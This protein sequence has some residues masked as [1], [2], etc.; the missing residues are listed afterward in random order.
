MKAN[1]RIGV[2]LFLFF[3]IV[4][5][6]QAQLAG[7]P[8]EVQTRMNQDYSR[9]KPAFEAAYE[10]CPTVPRGMLESVAYNYTRFSAPEW[11][12]TLDVD[13]NTIPRTYS[14][15]GLT[16]SGKGFFR[17]NLRLVSELSG[18][19]V[20]EIIRQD[21]MAI[22]AYALAFSSLQK[23][24]NC[25]GK[26]L[27]I[28]KPVLIDLSE[29]P[30]E[31]DFALLSSLYVIYFVFIDGILFHFGIP[32]FNVDFNILFGEKSAMLQQSN[33]SLD[34][35]YEQKATS[36][37]DYPSAVWN[38]AAS[39]NY[40]SRNGTQVSNVTIHY[41]SGTYAGSIAWFQNCAAKVS[42]H[43]V[44]RSI[45]GQ[46]TQMVRESSKAWHVGVAN[47]Y[48][49]GIEHEAY[50]N[51]A[52]FFTYNMYLSSA[53]LVRN[54]CSRYANI[55]P[56][57]VFYRDTL[58][59][60]TVLNNGLHSLGG[61]T[62]CTQIRGHQHFPSQT[63]TDPG[64]Y[65]DWNFYYKLINYPPQVDSVTSSTGVFY[66][67][68]GA[69]GNYQN[70]ERKLFLIHV[71]NADSVVLEFT[72]FQLEPNYD[73]IWIYAGKTEF[74]PLVGRW[75]THSPGRVA[76][77]GEY[78][79]VEFRS[80][81][82]TTAA[83]WKANWYGVFSQQQQDAAP[84]QTEIV[85]DHHEWIT[86]DFQIRFRDTDDVAVKY[87]FYQLMEHP[88][89]YWTANTQQGFLC[90]NFDAALSAS[91][92]YGDGYWQ[93][94]NGQLLHTPCMISPSWINKQLNGT[95][96]KGYLYDF[97]LAMQD[98]GE[99]SFIF[100]SNS[101]VQNQLAHAYGVTFCKSDNS[102]RMWKQQ[103][104]VMENL[105]TVTHV[106]YATGQ[107]MLYR[108][109]WDTVAHRIMVFRHSSL[110][111][112]VSVPQPVSS[113]AE[114]VGFITDGVGVSIDNMR[115][116]GMRDTSVLVTVGEGVDRML[117]T[118]ASGG[119]PT[120]KIKSV[121]M[122]EG[123]NFSALSE[124][125]VLV[126]YT[127]PD[128]PRKVRLRKENA[129]GGAE[130]G[131]LRVEAEWSPATDNQSGIKC[132]HYIYRLEGNNGPVLKVAWEYVGLSTSC[133]RKICTMNGMRLMVGV[134]AMDEAGWKSPISWSSVL[135]VE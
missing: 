96:H 77:G 67:S 26:E 22:M 103:N 16:L 111:A 92:W 83:G 29:I 80:D 49:I 125:S 113:S 101:V 78:M 17:E 52:A 118:Q 15:M 89:T 19:S 94:T 58:D 128:P 28:Y 21:S 74:S 24:Y 90:D 10:R 119:V 47:G 66:D 88:Q 75:N 124:K 64:P 127:M 79:L 27:E 53:A 3:L 120:C 68:G 95:R 73:F 71:P 44:I 50:G 6:L 8:P 102:L 40:S 32:D 18:I 65:W 7:L 38:P 30:V 105:K 112:D 69:T 117:Q 134:V 107:S 43:Y 12:D 93:V 46:V 48:T 91:G 14:V 109:V 132:Y 87:R 70:D 31:C 85:L 45:D 86:D 121:V 100:H 115:V 4:P 20:E 82:A 104:G 98:A 35:P 110:L 106:Y 114:Y 76:V 37:V 51:V 13:P 61:A 123:G 99:C 116:Y 129:N 2:F 81:C 63:H 72:E 33:V 126:D 60:G 42:A 57:R 59:D 135:L 62:S 34:Y 55:N 11:T 97:Y 56:L 25:Y 131:C 36:T 23:K 9:L 39:C 122:D 84:P 108:V 54:I 1:I 41:T 133:I 5:R 130:N